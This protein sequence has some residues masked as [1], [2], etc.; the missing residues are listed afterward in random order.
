[1]NN[2][3]KWIFQ[4]TFP[5]IVASSVIILFSLFG[6]NLAKSILPYYFLKTSRT[7]S[8]ETQP[9]IIIMG[10]SM[11]RHHVDPQIVTKANNLKLGTVINIGMNTATPLENF[12]LILA[13]QPL[14]K[15]VHTVYYSL[16]PWIYSKGYYK[17]RPVERL[18]LSRAEWKSLKKVF[19]IYDKQILLWRKVLTEILTSKPKV[20]RLSIENNFGFHPLLSKEKSTMIPKD[21]D[22][23]QYEIHQDL[24]IDETQFKNLAYISKYCENNNI[25]LV[26]FN[27]P[28]SQHVTKKLKKYNQFY[29]DTFNLLYSEL[30]AIRYVGSIKP[31]SYDLTKK[32]YYD[33]YHLTKSGAIKFTEKLFNRQSSH[34]LIPK[35]RINMG[36]FFE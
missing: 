13:N 18:L 28:K 12:Q 2:D 16:D 30:G 31:G 3:I 32:D 9:K 5:I 24:S 7:F 23:K 36:L 20:T 15:S 33:P 6:E 29:K 27:S 10:S 22:F 25:N 14:F 34:N 11:S 4:T 26:F 19:K 1:M 21:N 8:Y 17:H 35:R